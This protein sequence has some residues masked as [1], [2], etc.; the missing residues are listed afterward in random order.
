MTQNRRVRW[1]NSLEW[2]Y[3]CKS[4]VKEKIFFLHYLPTLLIILEENKCYIFPVQKR[5]FSIIATHAELKKNQNHY[6]YFCMPLSKIHRVY[7]KITMHGCI[8]VHDKY[9]YCML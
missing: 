4:I 1:Q 9:R 6:R 5:E 3:G 7:N 8:K 2:A